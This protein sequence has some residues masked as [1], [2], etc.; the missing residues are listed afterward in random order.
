VGVRV[1]LQVQPAAVLRAVDSRELARGSQPVQA[2]RVVLQRLVAAAPQAARSGVP[3]SGLDRQF[4][5]WPLRT[6]IPKN[7][8]KSGSKPIACLA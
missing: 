4:E 2:R 3:K 1:L 6:K 7:R 5:R 8:K